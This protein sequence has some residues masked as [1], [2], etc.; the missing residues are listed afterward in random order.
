MN[1]GLNIFLVVFLCVISY[2]GLLLSFYS[3]DD[4]ET[5]NP[6]MGY[7]KP[8]GGTYGTSAVSVDASSTGSDVAAIS[9][10]SAN[11]MFHH[12]P[13]FSYA[14]AAS[15]SAYSMGGSSS[16]LPFGEGVGAQGASPIYATSSAEF[17]SFGGGGNTGGVSMSGG[18]VSSNSQSPIANTQLAVQGGGFN[19]ITTSSPNSFNTSSFNNLINISP[20]SLIASLPASDYQGIA[21]MGDLRGIRGRQSAGPATNTSGWLNWLVLNG[22]GTQGADGIWGLDIYQLRQAYDDYV[23][24]WNSTMGKKPTWDEWLAWFMGSEDDPYGWT[25]DGGDTYSYY[26]YVPVGDATLLVLFALLYAVVLIIRRKK[27]TVS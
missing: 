19:G 22:Y 9:V 5:W 15:M 17:H 2:V 20:N 24:N 8:T 13:S 23:R 27:A 21:S 6:Q 14:P 3:S 11:S 25:N 4:S 1:K 10:R 26:K 16:I 12:H 7:A 18:V